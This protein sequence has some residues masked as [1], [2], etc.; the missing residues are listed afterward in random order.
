[1]TLRMEAG[2]SV[3]VSLLEMVEHFANEDAGC[4]QLR[5]SGVQAVSA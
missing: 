1:M 2:V 3:T 4:S 5:R